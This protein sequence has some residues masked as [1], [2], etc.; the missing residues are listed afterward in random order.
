MVAITSSASSVVDKSAAVAAAEA[1][2]SATAAGK[3]S[4]TSAAKVAQHLLPSEKAEEHASF[5][6]SHTAIGDFNEAELQEYLATFQILQTGDKLIDDNSFQLLK[7]YLLEDLNDFLAASLP[8]A[9]LLRDSLK[10]AIEP[11]R[12]YEKKLTILLDS[13]SHEAEGEDLS[14]CVEKI[15]TEMSN[16]ICDQ[17]IKLNK[18]LLEKCT[19]LKEKISQEASLSD[20]SPSVNLAE[21]CFNRNIADIH[22]YKIELRVDDREKN[23]DDSKHYYELAIKISKDEFPAEANLQYMSAVLNHCVFQYDC[24]G[25]HKEAFQELSQ[26][27]SIATKTLKGI[28]EEISPEYNE[29]IMFIS[30]VCL[31]NLQSWKRATDNGI[32]DVPDMAGHEVGDE[33]IDQTDSSMDSLDREEN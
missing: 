22:R 25:N 9:N 6:A 18:D 31:F 2:H 27:H 10:T 30:H 19:K 32:N 23:I 7:K 28:S 11:Y 24:L 3:M 1:G 5:V 20:F 26:V 13:E 8:T 17:W 33:N 21:S 4:N 29:G 12:N 14:K 15:R 16:E